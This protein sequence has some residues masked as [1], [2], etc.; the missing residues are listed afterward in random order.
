[1]RSG[2]LILKDLFNTI[3]GDLHQD[4]RS[5]CLGSWHDYITY[6]RSSHLLV[7][8]RSR[9]VFQVEASAEAR[10]TPQ[11]MLFLIL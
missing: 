10:L 2:F 7:L 6:L 9:C 8:K 1:M 3:S 4:Q 11:L 5:D